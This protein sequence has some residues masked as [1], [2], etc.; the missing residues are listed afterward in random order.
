[1]GGDNFRG[2]AEEDGDG[3]I[4]GET[5]NR[6]I[7]QHS[8]KDAVKKFPDQISSGRKTAIS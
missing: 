7:G 5:A 3:L 2:L 4:D 8:G 1:M 6:Q